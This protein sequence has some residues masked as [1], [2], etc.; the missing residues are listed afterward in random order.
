MAFWLVFIVTYFATVGE[1]VC[2]AAAAA[3]KRAMGLRRFAMDI[4]GLE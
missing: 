3:Q 4:M 1:R 2:P